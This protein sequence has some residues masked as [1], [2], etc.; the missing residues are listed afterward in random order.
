MCK[1]GPS[2]KR[3]R[4]PGSNSLP[5][6]QDCVEVLLLRLLPRFLGADRKP[7]ARAHHM[8]GLPRRELADV[9]RDLV[10][11]ARGQADLQVEDRAWKD[12]RAGVGELRR[13]QV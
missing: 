10:L 4:R 11:A 5:P 8:E 13:G 9:V 6:C 2:R 7:V 12:I 3:E 1:L